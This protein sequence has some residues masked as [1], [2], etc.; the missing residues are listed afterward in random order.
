MFLLYSSSGLTQEGSVNSDS[1][2]IDLP[3]GEHHINDIALNQSGSLLYSAGGNVVRVWDLRRLVCL[4]KGSYMSA[5]V[6]LN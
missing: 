6:L 2:K 3:V 1:R 4:Y 5:H